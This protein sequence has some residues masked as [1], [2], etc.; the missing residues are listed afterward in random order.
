MMVLFGPASAKGTLR[1]P[2]DTD[3]EKRRN[4]GAL[5]P[6]V[7][8]QRFIARLRQRQGIL[9]AGG[10]FGVEVRP[11]RLGLPAVGCEAGH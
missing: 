11:F 9:F 1:A 7:S 3:P 10:A 4:P 5:P 8:A 6:G 2:G